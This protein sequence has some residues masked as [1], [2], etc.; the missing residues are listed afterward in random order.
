M[1][2]NKTFGNIKKKSE[3]IIFQ[4]Y[5]NIYQKYLKRNID[6]LSYMK[7]K[8]KNVNCKVLE[9]SILNSKEY[10]SKPIHDNVFFNVFNNNLFVLTDFYKTKIK[11]NT[12]NKQI[13]IITSV[14]NG[15]KFIDQYLKCLSNFKYQNDFIYVVL[16]YYDDNQCK[17]DNITTKLI[18]FEKNNEN[19]CI[20]KAET[21]YN[22][23]SIWNEIIKITMT[24]YGSNFNIDDLP[25][26]NIYDILHTF[27]ITN[28]I[29]VCC[30]NF[31]IT[32]N[33]NQIYIINPLHN[34]KYIDQTEYNTNFCHSMLLWNKRIHDDVGYFEYCVDGDYILWTKYVKNKNIGYIEK[35]LYTCYENENTLSQRYVD[36]Q[37]QTLLS[38]VLLLTEKEITSGLFH[39]FIEKLRK[40]KITVSKDV[41]IYF[42]I[43][44]CETI[45]D[46]NK[47]IIITELNTIYNFNIIFQYVY[48]EK[49]D[50]I[51]IRENSHDN[52][53]QYGLRSG[54]NLQF[55]KTIST[56]FNLNKTKYCLF[57]ETDSFF[58]C[59]FW[60][61]I[62]SNY[63][64]IEHFWISGSLYK[65]LNNLH[66]SIKYHINGGVC[67]Y[68]TSDVDFKNE[69]LKIQLYFEEKVKANQELAYDCAIYMYCNE[70]NNYK[71]FLNVLSTSL[72]CNISC[73]ED[74][75]INHTKNSVLVHQK[76][77]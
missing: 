15:E 41:T 31:N 19:I 14:Y 63:C 27:C 71:T 9:N 45:S 12:L 39:K 13:T 46:K 62:F 6:K 7:Y 53:Y 35:P 20:I 58:V 66:P 23:Y 68:N 2:Q 67:L 32:Y 77:D 73:I 17:Q 64:E 43:S 4:N 59:D 21:N 34:K 24:P 10:K 52:T 56:L 29:D 51:Y 28:R 72:I 37:E 18:E 40:Y 1:E 54:P 76:I 55:F 61:D 11:N 48:I 5:N 50:N 38:I 65:G 74:K 49:K 36:T 70:L 75:N 33:Y 26:V 3:Q 22:I 8:E 42:I 16:V 57:L 25:N 60:Y 69:L 47:R 44:L 30:S